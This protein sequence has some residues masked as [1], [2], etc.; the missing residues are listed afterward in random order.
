MTTAA[1][2]ILLVED[3]ENDVLFLERAFDK[4][5]AP[6]P[7]RVLGDGQEAIAYLSGTGGFEDRSEHPA[8]SH[9]ILDLKIPR[10]NGFEVL[11]WL[12]KDPRWK[13]LRVVTL[14][15]SGDQGDRDRA[16]ALG[17]DGYFVKPSRHPALVEVAKQIVSLWALGEAPPSSGRPISPAGGPGIEAPGASPPAALLELFPGDGEMQSLMRRLDWQATPVGPIATW[18]EHLRTAVR[19]CVTSTFPMSVW[20][21]H[22]YTQ[23]YNDAYRP[24][25]GNKHPMWLGR[26]GKECWKDIWHQVGPMLE[27]VRSTGRATGYQD[28]QIVMDRHLPRE[29]TYF[30]LSVSPI[31]GRGSDV[32]G[33][34]CVCGE[35]TSRVVSQ[36]RLQ[37]LRDLA[38]RT[39]QEKDET[40]ACKA[41]ATI[42]ADNPLDVPFALIYLADAD[43]ASTQLAAAAGMRAGTADA[44]LV[45]QTSNGNTTP[46]PLGVVSR[47]GRTRQLSSILTSAPLPGGP[48][49]EPASDVF[50]LPLRPQGEN[51]ITGFLIVGA[52]PRR[53]LDRDYETFFELVAAQIG[54]AVAHAHAYQ[55]ER[56]RAESLAELDRAKTAFFSNVSHEFRTPLTLL[57]G[58]LEDTLKKD[59]GALQPDD[60]R[61]IETAHRNALRLLKLTNMLLDFSRIEAGRIEAAYEAV[62]LSRLTSEVA[63]VFRSAVERMGLRFRV[64]CQRLPDSV[65]VDRE[66]W[67]KIVL[68]LLSNALKFT[69]KGEIAVTLTDRGK[70]A[71]LSVRD[72]GTGIPQVELPRLFE[73]FHRVHGSRAR[74]LE[75]SGIGLAVVQELA[76]LHGATVGVQSQI[77]EGTAFTV[78]IPYGRA[79]LPAA[80]IRIR[81]GSGSTALAAAAF[82][83]DAAWWLPES[84]GG[85]FAIAAARDEPEPI[86][87]ADQQPARVIVAD[88]N[89]DMREYV[90]E[91]LGRHWSVD[92]VP[93]GAVALAHAQESPPDLVVADVMMAELDGLGLLTELRRDA[94]TRTVPVILLSA[95]AGD[96]ARAEGFAAGADDYLTKPFSARELLARTGALLELSRLR[97]AHEQELAKLNTELSEKVRDLEAFSSSVAHDLR[98][99][100]RSVQTLSGFLEEEFSAELPPTAANYLHRIVGSIKRME[101]LIESLLEYSR[102]TRSEIELEPVSAADMMREVLDT[103][104]EEVQRRNGHVTVDLEGVVAWADRV[105]LS[106]IFRNL[107]SNALKF[108]RPGVSPDVHVGAQPE[109]DKVRLWVQDNGIGIEPDARVRLSE[110]FFRLNSTKD[111]PGS[112]LGLAIV[113][114]ASE[115]MGG[116]WGFDSALGQGSRFWIEL[117]AVRP[118]A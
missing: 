116:R 111:Y 19:I 11:E 28:L 43:G 79:H 82:L 101:E 54:T 66:M 6:R 103:L 55:E 96:D 32:D 112:G 40:E 47:E 4:A 24:I 100:L 46:W 33:L 56:H 118:S 80:K 97:R 72:T 14:T 57:L 18:P 117:E 22:D 113:R 7:F 83:E 64:D 87:L 105:M 71:E 34:L 114:R 13:D 85:T 63:S 2:R 42:L 110:A 95:R 29:E 104:S 88:D 107:V 74:T 53:I 36:R 38:A 31:L 45:I 52:S 76:R 61:R 5:G 78:S 109:A 17:V 41:A 16:R 59:P 98:S 20:W 10:R 68:N 90:S 49:P 23:F 106:Q 1:P 91:I 8:P 92:A 62:D 58:P 39:S 77:G 89:R 81:R 37:T 35:T 60:R 9:L 93:N 65:F 51:R 15:S 67:E 108:T 86:P 50:I 99:P 94:R 102:L 115:R 27:G 30:T 84:P 70:R 12:R 75:G 21:G 3:D 44:P 73:R 25:L 26:S 48:W 69:F